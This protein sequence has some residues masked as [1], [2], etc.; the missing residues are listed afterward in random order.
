MFFSQECVLARS[1]SYKV[2]DFATNRKS[3]CDFLLVRH[4]NLGPIL[5]RFRNIAGFCAPDP[6]VV[7]KYVDHWRMLQ[8]FHVV[9][10]WLNNK[11]KCKNSDESLLD[12]YR[13][14]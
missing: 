1:R 3:I 7:L 10:N 6:A 12:V 2:I 11:V 5:H 13:K 14:N 4:S 8:H 9:R